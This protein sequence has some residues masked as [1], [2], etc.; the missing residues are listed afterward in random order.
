MSTVSLLRIDDRLIHGQV[1][2]G[3]VKHIN[4]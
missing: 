4:A 3:W 2:T 1:M